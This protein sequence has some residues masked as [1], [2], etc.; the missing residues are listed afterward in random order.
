M[1]RDYD[2][3]VWDGDVIVNCRDELLYSGGVSG[4]GIQC[5]SYDHDVTDRLRRACD[6]ISAG[7]I[8]LD[9]I[10]NEIKNDN[11]I[12]RIREVCD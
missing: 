8:A 12:G 2:V 3:R 1:Y 5:N 6:A 11:Y 7:M 9:D 4:Y 10:L